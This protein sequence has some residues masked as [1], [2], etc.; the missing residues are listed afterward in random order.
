MTSHDRCYFVLE[1]GSL[2]MWRLKQALSVVCHFGGSGPNSSLVTSPLGYLA[3]YFLRGTDK[4]VPSGAVRSLLITCTSLLWH[5]L[6]HRRHSLSVLRA[7]ETSLSLLLLKVSL[8]CQLLPVSPWA[9]HKIVC[10]PVL[11]PVTEPHISQ[12]AGE[13]LVK[14]GRKYLGICTLCGRPGLGTCPSYSLDE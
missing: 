1:E 7:S 11:H 9:L 12:K 2:G 10:H 3:A 13:T 6:C 14:E 8:A 4:H 5:F